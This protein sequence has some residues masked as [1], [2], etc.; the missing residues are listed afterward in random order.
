MT[1]TYPIRVAI[2]TASDRS[3]RGERPDAAGPALEQIA[4]AQGWLVTRREILPDEFEALR[5]RLCA[6][7]DDGSVDLI[8][9]TGGTGFSSR[10]VTPEVVRAVVD[11]LTPGL[12]EAMRQASL[13]ITP[14]AMLSRAVCGIRK[15]A[16]I[17]TLPGS[18][19]AAT[20]NLQVILV[21]LPHAVSLLR[22]E[23]DSH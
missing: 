7:A 14:H 11:R 16:L 3:A 1:G 9:V 20:E 19:K 6:W 4:N 23:A 18:P 17:V 2:L 5:A 13:A 15:R 8:L 12:D 21:A 10:D 22:D